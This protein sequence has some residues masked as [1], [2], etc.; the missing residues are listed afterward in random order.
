MHH[1]P[2]QLLLQ[3]ISSFFAAKLMQ[4]ARLAWAPF[5]QFPRRRNNSQV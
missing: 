2:N 5:Y 4:L 3:L 1:Q